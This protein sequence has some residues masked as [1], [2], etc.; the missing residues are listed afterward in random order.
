MT[1]G[2]RSSAA[3]PRRASA[4]APNLSNSAPRKLRRLKIG[5]N[6]TSRRS[7]NN[8]TLSAT[9]TM[10]PAN[11][12]RRVQVLAGVD[13]PAFRLRGINPPRDQRGCPPPLDSPFN[14]ARSSFGELLDS[15]HALFLASPDRL[16]RLSRRSR[17]LLGDVAALGRD[18]RQT[19]RKSPLSRPRAQVL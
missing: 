11:P 17:W 19:R 18:T 13:K 5:S 9:I 14:G 8:S 3:S 12:T 6:T 2:T 4:N 15:P 7:A 16:D 1:S 10:P